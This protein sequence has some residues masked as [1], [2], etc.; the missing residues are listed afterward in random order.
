VRQFKSPLAP[1]TAM[2]SISSYSPTSWKIIS[3]PPVSSIETTLQETENYHVIYSNKFVYNCFALPWSFKVVLQAIKMGTEQMQLLSITSTVD[4]YLGFKCTSFEKT[5]VKT[6]GVSHSYTQLWL[7]QVSTRLFKSLW[8]A[9]LTRLIKI[10]N[11]PT[12]FF[13]SSIV[14]ATILLMKI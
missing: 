5:N 7:L 2:D 1:N 14:H 12:W 9:L 6:V 4:W 8:Y 11:A 10:L 3:A 13:C